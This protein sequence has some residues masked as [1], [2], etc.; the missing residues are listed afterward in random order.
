VTPVGCP[1]AKVRPSGSTATDAAGVP[2][3][4]QA[5]A[6]LSAAKTPMVAWR[7]GCPRLAGWQE[8]AEAWPAMATTGYFT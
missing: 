4:V 3:S 8:A 2:G 5:V 1:I 7:D 6:T